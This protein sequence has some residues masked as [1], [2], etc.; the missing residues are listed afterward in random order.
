MAL[1]DAVELGTANLAYPAGYNQ[2]TSYRP[3]LRGIKDTKNFLFRC[4]VYFS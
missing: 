2:G 1:I 3:M 4:Q